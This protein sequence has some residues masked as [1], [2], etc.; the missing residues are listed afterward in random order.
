MNRGWAC[1]STPQ[2]N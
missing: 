1:F 2:K